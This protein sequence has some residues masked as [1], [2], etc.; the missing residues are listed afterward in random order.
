M[1]GCVQKYWY[2][3][4]KSDISQNRIKKLLAKCT[5]LL[6]GFL[7][8]GC[9]LEKTATTISYIEDQIEIEPQYYVSPL[10]NEEWS[11]QNALNYSEGFFTFPPP[12]GYRIMEYSS[13]PTTVVIDM[14]RETLNV[15]TTLA[16][17]IKRRQGCD[18]C[19]FNE[20][21]YE[22]R[23]D[24]DMVQVEADCYRW[25]SG[26][27][28][29][30]YYFL[31]SGDIVYTFRMIS[32]LDEFEDVVPEFDHFVNYTVAQYMQYPA[33]HDMQPYEHYAEDKLDSDLL[34]FF[35]PQRKESPAQLRLPTHKRVP[36]HP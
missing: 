12:A 2:K 19:E 10:P 32:A 21:E 33:E 18:H 15:D 8:F 34:S 28:K 7:V 26:K 31:R 36:M 27:L 29:R 4:M 3:G 5:F 20:E 17:V 13:K 1:K 6:A 30:K 9:A 16:K 24:M 25:Y 14:F 23:G 11:E 35:N 22:E